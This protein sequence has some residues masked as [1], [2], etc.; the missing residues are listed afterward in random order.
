MTKIHK[1]LTIIVVIVMN[2][3]PCGRVPQCHFLM[4]SLLLLF[5]NDG[6][7]NHNNNI[8][9]IEIST[10][11]IITGELILITNSKNNYLK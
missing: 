1:L 8:H 9:K 2:A 3:D 7:K 6:N 5:H 4:L 11:I 10:T